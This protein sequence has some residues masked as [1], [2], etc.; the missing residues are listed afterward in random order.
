MSCSRITSFSLTILNNSPISVL[1]WQTLALGSTLVRDG[2]Q[3]N[4]H[5]RLGAVIEDLGVLSYM[6]PILL[7]EEQGVET[8]I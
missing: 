6:D 4:T 8:R 2:H 3:S 1:S 7:S 5:L